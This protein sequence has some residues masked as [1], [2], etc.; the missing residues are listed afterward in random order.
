MNGFTENRAPGAYERPG[1]HD[2][3]LTWGA[4]HA[5]LPLVGRIVADI[6]HGHEQLAQLRPEQERLDRQRHTLAWPERSRRYQ[7]QEEI[8]ALETDLRK[9]CTELE[10]LGVAVLHGPSGLVGF[11]TIVND[12]RAFFS[13]RP[14]EEDVVYWNFAGDPVR[15]AVPESWTKTPPAPRSRRGKSR[16]KQA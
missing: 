10:S 1:P 14:G 8:T 12:R 16:R 11:P 15:H 6:M 4:S 3:V 9:A 13:W 2:L 7:V 5:M